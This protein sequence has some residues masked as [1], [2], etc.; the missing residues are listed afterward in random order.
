MPQV[1]AF[2]GAKGSGKD[3]AASFLAHE[4]GIAPIAFADPIKK[5]IMWTFKI[6]SVA[7]YDI[8]KRSTI[9]TPHGEVDGRHIVREIGM[10]MRRYDEEQFIQYVDETVHRNKNS[11]FAITDLRFDNEMQYCKHI[12]AKV[13]KLVRPGSS[14]DGH[15]TER[16][17]DN[18]ECDL[19]VYNDTDNVKSFEVQL[20]EIFDKK[21]NE[22]RWL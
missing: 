21:L 12:G 18:S 5:E 7:D 17:F 4:Y 15:V 10:L 6:R 19:V 2:T 11:K 9:K 8:F 14:S 16:G 22:W 3:T 20:R 1:I 13:I